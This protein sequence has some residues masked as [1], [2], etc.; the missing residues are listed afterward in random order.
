MLA[1]GQPELFVLPAL[2]QPLAAKYEPRE[3]AGKAAG[4]E[5]MHTACRHAHGTTWPVHQSIPTCFLRATAM[6]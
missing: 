3:H 2:L 6:T 4:S 1:P 5:R